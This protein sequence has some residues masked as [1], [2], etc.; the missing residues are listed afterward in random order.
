[1]EKPFVKLIETPN[2]QYCYDVN[3]N[4]ILNIS[5]KQYECIEAILNENLQ[6]DECLEHL[7]KKDIFQV[8]EFYR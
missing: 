7:K 6:W 1:M 5:K 8:K 4:K 3:T 2:G